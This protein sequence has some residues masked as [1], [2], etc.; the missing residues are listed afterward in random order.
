M[1]LQQPQQQGLLGD[2]RQ[3]FQG[4]QPQAPMAAPNMQQTMV[5]QTPTYGFSPEFLQQLMQQFPQFNYQ[6]QIQNQQP[7][8]QTYGLLSN[9]GNMG[10]NTFGGPSATGY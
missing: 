4:Y 8:Q 9:G 2:W 10:L 5:G 7:T 3:A 6:Q 1:L